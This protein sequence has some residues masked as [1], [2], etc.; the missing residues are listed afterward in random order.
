MTPA[1]EDF[2]NSSPSPG[3]K[4]LRRERRCRMAAF[5]GGSM[6]PGHHDDP[7]HCRYPRAHRNDKQMT[8]TP[9]KGSTTAVTLD[10]APVLGA[11]NRTLVPLWAGRS[12]RPTGGMSTIK[13]SPGKATAVVNGLDTP[14]DMDVKVVPII[15]AGRMPLPLRFVAESLRATVGYDRAART[16][17]ITCLAY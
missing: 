11:G 5:P 2:Q 12:P 7:L 4:E 3:G 9:Q 13:L 10:A 14:L 8:I 1:N 15:V 16:I 17:T 6:S